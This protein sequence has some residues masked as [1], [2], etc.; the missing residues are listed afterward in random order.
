M[1]GLPLDSWIRFG[2]WLAIGLVIYAVYGT[3]HSRVARR[4]YP[5]RD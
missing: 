3:K 1:L 4:A 2:L 5:S